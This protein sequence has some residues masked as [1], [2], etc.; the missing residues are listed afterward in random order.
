MDRKTNKALITIAENVLK[1]TKEES[2]SL[3]KKKG[4]NDEILESYNGQVAALGVSILMTGLKPTLA[5]YY[6]D[7]PGV[8]NGS[9]DKAYREYV[10]EIIVKMLKA[11]K[12]YAYENA[13][14]LVRK[15]LAMDDDSKLKTDIINCSVALKQVVRTYNLV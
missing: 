3:F 15:A 4:V 9:P 10:L 5:I 7:A 6:Q 14:E 1:D 13:K 2:F 11:Y 12:N 8:E